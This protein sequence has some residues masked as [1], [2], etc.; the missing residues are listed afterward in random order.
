MLCRNKQPCLRI[1]YNTNVA[2]KRKRVC[3]QVLTLEPARCTAIQI[4]NYISSCL[5]EWFIQLYESQF[6]TE[7]V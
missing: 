2:T 6:H 7:D 5:D 1:L 4:F 3:V